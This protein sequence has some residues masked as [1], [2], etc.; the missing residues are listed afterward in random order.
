MA[1]KDNSKNEPLR[2]TAQYKAVCKEGDLQ[3]KWRT[4]EDEAIR[5]GLDHQ[6][7]HPSHHFDILVE[8]TEQFIAKI[9][10]DKID[11]ARK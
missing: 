1:K 11:K 7:K 9:S 3:S 8:Q 10:K 2:S 5:D 4:T 6:D